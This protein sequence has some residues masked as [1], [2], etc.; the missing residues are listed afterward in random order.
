MEVMEVFESRIR[1]AGRSRYSQ[2]KMRNFI[3]IGDRLQP[4]A[5]THS[6]HFMGCQLSPYAVQ[7][8]PYAPTHTCLG[9]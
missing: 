7:L 3:L 9:C 6:F 5:S 8:S 2:F 4:Y 1:A